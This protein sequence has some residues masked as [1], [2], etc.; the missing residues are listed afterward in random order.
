MNVEEKIKHDKNKN[1]RMNVFELTVP[2]EY[3]DYVNI[4]HSKEN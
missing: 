3:S 2:S 4:N 1:R